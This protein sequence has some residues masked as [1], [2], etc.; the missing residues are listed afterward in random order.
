MPFEKFDVSK[1]ERLN[2]EARFEALPPEVM[3]RALGDPTPGTIVDIGAGTGLFS[4]RFAAMAPLAR[5]FAV[6]ASPVM[7]GWMLEHLPD[8]LAG[9][10][11]PVLG[12]E[13]LVPLETASADLVVMIHVH[14]ELAEPGATYR[15][16]LRL[17]RPAGQ[18]LVVDWAPDGLPGGPPETVRASAVE[19]ARMLAGA[20]FADVTTHP[21]LQRDSMITARRP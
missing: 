2:D 4:R 19:I 18:I 8:D 17:L 15:E 7:V 16:A 12:A 1:L 13:A 11:V 9:R 10:V 3:W 14:H 6:D 20:G 5:V 21:P